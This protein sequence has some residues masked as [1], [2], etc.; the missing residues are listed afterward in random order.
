MPRK[1]EA[2]ALVLRDIPNVIQKLSIKVKLTMET[3]ERYNDRTRKKVPYFE[4]TGSILNC[5]FEWLRTHI[6]LNIQK[7]LIVKSLNR[8]H[9]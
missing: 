5:C 4:L 1:N 3:I 6:L 2:A 8:F 7:N 9:R